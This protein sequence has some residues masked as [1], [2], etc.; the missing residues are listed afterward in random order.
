[1]RSELTFTFEFNSPHG[2][3]HGRTID[4]VSDRSPCHRAYRDSGEGWSGFAVY[5]ETKPFPAVTNIT[6]YRAIVRTPRRHTTVF[7]VRQP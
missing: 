6:G 5:L 7:M 3:L 2:T 4:P 1:M